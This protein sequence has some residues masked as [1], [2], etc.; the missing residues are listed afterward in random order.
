MK[1]E[2]WPEDVGCRSYVYKKK[3]YNMNGDGNKRPNNE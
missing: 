3:I 1:N 2:L